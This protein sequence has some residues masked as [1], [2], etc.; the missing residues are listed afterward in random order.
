M[1]IYVAIFLLISPF[2][3][4]SKTNEQQKETAFIPVKSKIAFISEESSPLIDG[5]KQQLEKV[6]NFVELPDKTEALQDAL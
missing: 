6:A 3:S 2:M 1:L 5:L 4:S